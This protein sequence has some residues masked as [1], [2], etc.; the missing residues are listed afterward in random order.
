MDK[1]VKRHA[2]DGSI[3]YD[4]FEASEH[5]IEYD[6]RGCRYID[7]FAA[8]GVRPLCKI[9]CETDTRSYAH[10]TRHVEFVRHSDLSDGDSCH[11]E[12]FARGR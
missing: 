5:A 9:F 6:I 12:I 7:M 11:D 1:R 2:K 10:L 4:H 8:W 3:D